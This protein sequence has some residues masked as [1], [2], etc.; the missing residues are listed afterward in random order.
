MQLHWDVTVTYFLISGLL[1][2]QTFSS[3]FLKECHMLQN[4]TLNI[5]CCALTARMSVSPIMVDNFASLIK[6]T[7][8]SLTSI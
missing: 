4:D 7:K 6:C 3:T 8:M 1:V 5:F 2:M